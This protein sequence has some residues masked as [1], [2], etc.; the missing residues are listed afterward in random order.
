[1]RKKKKSMTSG[2]LT[3]LKSVCRTHSHRRKFC[4][5]RGIGGDTLN[6]RFACV[7]MHRHCLPVDTPVIDYNVKMLKA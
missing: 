4:V 7:Y 5:S 3:M 6:K 2:E 1:M